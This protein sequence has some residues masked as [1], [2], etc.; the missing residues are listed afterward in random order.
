VNELAEMSWLLILGGWGLLTSW[1]IINNRERL[2]YLEGLLFADA[3]HYRLPEGQTILSD[4]TEE[5]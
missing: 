5:E 4:F 3:G 2:S 1:L